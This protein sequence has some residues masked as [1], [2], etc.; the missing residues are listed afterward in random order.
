[1]LLNSEGFCRQSVS[2]LCR[3]YFSRNFCFLCDREWSWSATLL[4][5]SEFNSLYTYCF[6]FAHIFVICDHL[7]CDVL[8]L[9][10]PS[11][12]GFVT[13]SIILLSEIE[14]MV[15]YSK[16]IWIVFH[17][18]PKRQIFRFSL[19]IINITELQLM[20]IFKTIFISV[21]VKKKGLGFSGW[22]RDFKDQFLTLE[23]YII[24]GSN[25]RL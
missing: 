18:K 20:R 21:F 19:N 10:S 6:C 25:T 11:R 24:N 1:M 15:F 13:I 4:H 16:H 23:F 2:L 12:A 14:I 9:R 8:K 22:Q 17:E 5:F 7:G 3:P